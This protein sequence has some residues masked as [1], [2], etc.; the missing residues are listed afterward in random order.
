MGQFTASTHTLSN[1]VNAQADWLANFL[2]VNLT[3][4]GTIIIY[5]TTYGRLGQEEK[6][7]NSAMTALTPS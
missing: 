4:I 7:I 2:N 5:F 6:T 3:T 1:E